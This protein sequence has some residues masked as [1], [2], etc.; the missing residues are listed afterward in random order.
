MP[1]AVYSLISTCR[2]TTSSRSPLAQTSC[3]PPWRVRCQPSSRSCLSRSR[4]FI[5]SSYTNRCICQAGVVRRPVALPQGLGR[6]Y[7]W[8]PDSRPDQTGRAGAGHRAKGAQ[9]RRVADNPAVLCGQVPAPCRERSPRIRGP[10]PD[11][12]IR[13]NPALTKPRRI[14]HSMPTAA[15]ASLRPPATLPASRSS[16]SSRGSPP[17]SATLAAPR[18][19]GNGRT[20]FERE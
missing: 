15:L 2:G 8:V 11:Q 1:R 7:L 5:H 3:L 19:T 17:G 6:G 4:R 10:D 12:L 13:G 16:P 20:H 18:P 14:F 9:L